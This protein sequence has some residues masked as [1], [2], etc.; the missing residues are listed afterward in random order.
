MPPCTARPGCMNSGLTAYRTRTWPGSRDSTW[1]S[2]SRAMGASLPRSWTSR[3]SFSSW[4]PPPPPSRPVIWSGLREAATAEGGLL[5]ARPGCV[6]RGGRGAGSNRGW[7]ETGARRSSAAERERDVHRGRPALQAHRELVALLQR[8]REALE[9]GERADALAVDLPDDVAPLDARLRRRA[10][11]LDPRD[12][13][14]LARAQ[15]ELA[16]DL[17]RD[18]A[19]LE[20]EERARA[21]LALLELALLGRLADLHLDGA[22]ALLAPDLE[23]GALA[24]GEEADGA[25]EV[26]RALHPLALELEQDVAGLEA[27]PR[28]RAVGHDVRDQHAL[29]VL[30]AEGARELGRE[31]LDRHAEPAPRAFALREQLDV[32][33]AR[34]VGGDREADPRAARDDRRVDADHLALHVHQRPARVAGVDRRVGLEEVV[35]GALADLPGL[36]ADDAGRDGGLQPERRAD[37]EHPVTDLHPVGVAEPGVVERALAVVELQDREVGLLV[38]ADDLGPVLAAVERDDL[39]V[40][41]A[42]DDV[43]VGQRDAGRVDDDARAEAALRDPLGHLAEE[44]PE[45]LLAEELLERRAA[46]GAAGAARH[47]VDVDDGRLDRLRHLCERPPR[48]RHLHRQGGG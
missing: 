26:A 46:R 33:L 44:P 42:I 24:R 37:R 36:G 17:G 11:L 34:H 22:L 6:C 9:V 19:H 18:R 3:R 39:D 23:P 30:G 45:E 38:Q 47:R 27:R 13:D 29:D 32:A 15:V 20:A 21:T 1:A 4:V 28:R 31:R 25:L 12:D 10:A 8:A 43:R 35:E 48:D 41:R 5:P 40:G 16:G 2:T 14:A 7:P